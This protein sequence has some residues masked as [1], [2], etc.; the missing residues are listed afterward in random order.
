MRFWDASALVPLLVE[1]AATDRMRALLA[2]DPDLVVWWATPVECGS[3]LARLARDV[4]DD[5]QGL[6]HAAAVLDE[7]SAGWIEVAPTEP[8]RRQAL[9]LLRVHALRAADALQ[10]AAAL[11][12]GGGR[13]G[14]E[15]VSLDERLS[16]AARLEG[17]APLS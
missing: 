3:A 10:L 17:L 11:A 8:V 5:A 12:W 15:L 16:E 9:R 2:Q 4:E 6:G 13:L 14:G 1:Q 7:L